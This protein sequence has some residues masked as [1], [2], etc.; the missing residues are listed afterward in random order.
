MRFLFH[1][2]LIIGITG[3]ASV[4]AAPG[5]ADEWVLRGTLVRSAPDGIAIVE[6][7]QSYEQTP[8]RVGDLLAEDVRLDA[9]YTD[10]AQVRAGGR[11]YRLDF[12]QRV[13]D[14]LALD[15][16]RFRLKWSELPALFERLELIPH[17]QDGRV[18]G[19][20]ANRIDDKIR[21]GIGLQPGD[22]LLKING[23]PLN[24]DL[25]LMTLYA[26]LQDTTVQVEVKRHGQRIQL[27][28]EIR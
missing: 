28:Y 3:P 9:V 16:D 5:L 7:L 26:S 13:S 17:Q 14:A 22:L 21:E 23:L 6:H 25:D 24:S 2:C 1:L 8:V 27:A 19:Y 15:D 11:V 12:G 20:Y 10:H 4:R 18:V